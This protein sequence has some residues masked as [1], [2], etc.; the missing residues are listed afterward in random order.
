MDEYRKLNIFISSHCNDADSNY[1]IIRKALKELLLSTGL[2][3]HVYLFEDSDSRSCGVQDAYLGEI[4]MS[5]LVIFIVMNKDGVRSP[6]I[7]ESQYATQLN[8]RR[9]YVFCEESESKKTN[10]QI[11]IEKQK[12]GL[13][14][15][16]VKTIR[17]IVPKAYY[18]FIGDVVSSYQRKP[19]YNIEQTD[20]SRT[21]TI[22]NESISYSDYPDSIS[23]PKKDIEGFGAITNSI[24]GYYSEKEASEESELIKAMRLQL[25]A[26]LFSR[27][28][29]ESDYDSY[30]GLVLALFADNLKKVI[31]LR[32]DALKFYNLGRYEECLLKLQQCLLLFNT[33]NCPSW[34]ILD[35]AID[36]RHVHNT[37]SEMK[38]KID[39]DNEGQKVIN[40]SND[41]IYYPVLD[42]CVSGIYQKLTEEYY[43]N[44]HSSPFSIQYK[45]YSRLFEDLA[46]SFGFASL[47]GSIVQTSLT[48][49]RLEDIYQCLS[50]FY[51]EKEY[52]VELQ[53]LFYIR[54]NQKKI[55]A[56]SN[57]YRYS[58]AVINHEDVTTIMASLSLIKSDYQRVKALLLMA[59]NAG[60]YLNDDSFEKLRIELFSVIEKLISGKLM[61][62]ILAG[63]FL[64]FIKRM[65]GRVNNNDAVDAVLRIVPF[66]G[67]GS[68]LTAFVVL[69]RIHYSECDE[70]TINKVVDYLCHLVERKTY[71]GFS[72]FR[73]VIISV[74]KN[75]SCQMEIANCVKTNWNEFY[76]D[77]YLLNT[78]ES[79]DEYRRFFNIYLNRIEEWNNTE[80]SSGSYDISSIS[81]YDVVRDILEKNPTC[82]GADEI[83]LICE[84]CKKG[85]EKANHTVET[86]RSICRLIILLKKLFPTLEALSI[87]LNESE[88]KRQEYQK[89][90]QSLME[91]EDRMDC[92]MFDFELMLLSEKQSNT[93]SVVEILF[94]NTDDEYAQIQFLDSINFFLNSGIGISDANLANTFLQFSIMCST[95]DQLH[96]SFHSVKCLISLLNFL[97]D[98]QLVLSHLS[99]AMD[100]GKA[101]VR[102][103]IVHEMKKR[104]IKPN[105]LEEMI[106]MKGKSDNNFFVRRIA[107]GN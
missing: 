99:K 53:R 23:I 5:D 81:P 36:I 8:K 61:N 102:C 31:D 10:L 75:T 35:V 15:S 86:K 39:L 64:G 3:E 32:L 59:A 91:G 107:I 62:D 30:K 9:L 25:E 2:V 17:D 80:G 43:S 57:K 12:S 28:F 88:N 65:L 6:V 89:A 34:I 78:T 74:S 48:I 79:H 46:V 45:S 87:F 83:A 58:E 71:N 97:E 84:K 72:V 73:K 19:S 33:I 29:D 76:S 96:V 66:C 77:F 14:F 4:E 18:S 47:H 68:I 16:V 106:I 50:T 52:Y 90:V 63:L 40:D 101:D 26:C 41:Y 69:S 105:S 60:V 27:E 20:S 49:D 56:F 98:T 22:D 21:V 92:F 44:Q 55:D 82:I 11:D 42:R 38:G 54:G 104:T 95:S 67:I 7:T 13:K 94:A 70:E 37:I 103:L 51:A 1:L 93:N 100:F 24:L 85:F